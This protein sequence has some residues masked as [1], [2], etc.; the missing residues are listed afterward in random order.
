MKIEKLSDLTGN[1]WDDLSAREQREIISREA[2][3]TYR[4]WQNEAAFEDVNYALPWRHRDRRYAPEHM[5]VARFCASK[6]REFDGYMRVREEASKEM[7][8]AFS[9]EVKR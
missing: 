9:E 4:S 8:V 5:G 3:K 7:S 1:P 2:D 6:V